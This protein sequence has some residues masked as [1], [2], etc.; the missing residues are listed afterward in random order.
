[1]VPSH[2]YGRENRQ[3]GRELSRID[4]NSRVGLAHIEQAADMQ[5]ARVHSLG[6][7]GKQALHAAAMVSETEQ[8]LC[9]LVP[10]AADRLTAIGDITTLGLAEIVTDTV[11]RVSR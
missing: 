5:A 6:Y 4:G 9:R 8:Q 10:E 11:R 7:V 3:L 1:M 2:G